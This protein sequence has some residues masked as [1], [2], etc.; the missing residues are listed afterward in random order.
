MEEQVEELDLAGLSAPPLPTQYSWIAPVAVASA[1]FLGTILAPPHL[2]D[3]VDGVQAQIARNMLDSGDW[4]TPRLNGIADFE[5]PPFL[6]WMIAASFALFGIS[7]WAARLPV[8]I[9]AVVLCF[10]VQQIGT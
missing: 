4:I 6:Y 10:L 9:S 1:I 7:D 3:D 2:L 8:A 5:K